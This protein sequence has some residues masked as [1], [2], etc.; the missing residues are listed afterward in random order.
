MKYYKQ[1]TGVLSANSYLAVDQLSGESVI[2]D[3]GGFDKRL[4]NLLS[5]IDE[6]KLKYIILTHRHYDHLAG[7]EQLR[8]R[9]GAKVLISAEDKSGLYDDAASLAKQFRATLNKCTEFETVADG[10]EIPFA[11][12][13]IK[14]LATPGHT[15]GGLSFILDDLLITGDTL[16]AGDIGRTDLASADENDMRNSL[17]R[18]KALDHDY[19]VLP[20]HGRESTLEY[21][22]AHNPYFR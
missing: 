15:V 11:D 18:L 12:T 16:F 10:D 19:K 7:V 17:D 1:G 9:T 4:L 21:E 6:S 13:V 2:F 8:A 14:V 3:V 5:N 20:G 22:K